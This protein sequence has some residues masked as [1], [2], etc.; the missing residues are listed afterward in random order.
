M[1]LLGEQANALQ[2]N[3]ISSEI[4]IIQSR[5]EKQEK[6]MLSSRENNANSV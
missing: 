2:K 3:E 1:S 6:Y 4:L 5:G